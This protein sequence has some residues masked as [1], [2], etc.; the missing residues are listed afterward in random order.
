MN[1]GYSSG[2]CEESFGIPL[3][4]SEIMCKAR[5]DS[6]CRFIMAHPH[7]MAQYIQAYLRSHPETSDNATLYRTG[8]FFQQLKQAQENLR[9]SEE[10]FKQ[11]AENAGDWI[12]EVNAEGLYTY[13]S[14]V[15]EKVLGYKPEEIVGKKYLYDFFAPEVKEVLKKAAFEVLNRRESFVGFVN[16]VIHK[17]GSTIIMETTG[18]PV[19]DDKGNL[20]GYRGADKDV[21]ERKRAEQRQTQLLEQLEK[22]NKQLREFAHLTAHDLKTPLRGIG[23][24]AQ[25]LSEDYRGKFDDAGQRQID[26]LVKRVERMDK[27]ID[28]VLIYSTITRNKQNE[29]K[30]D[31]NLLINVVLAEIKPPQNI[32]ITI[33]KDL[34]T[35]ICD[36]K[37]I[38]QVFHNLLS[39]AVNFMNK[40]EGL[41]IVDCAEESDFLKFSV[42]DNGPGIEPQHFDRIFRLFQT[43]NDRD[44]LETTGAGLALAKKIVELYGGKIWLTSTV[45]EGSTFFFT[46]SKQMVAVA[47]QTPQPAAT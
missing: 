21:T 35:I 7:K 34:P 9:K 26:L 27:L 25:W 8:G 36:E 37:Y 41:I 6:A 40:P 5:G 18:T 42:S 16:P 14:P 20:C 12:W 44:Q 4:A 45:G 1:A 11:V 24:L 17:N 31:L 30:T 2:W 29:R 46:L 32:E 38:A 47:A 13:S 3:V 19:L 39:N 33:N 15:A 43:L 23:M 28:A 10:R 22:T